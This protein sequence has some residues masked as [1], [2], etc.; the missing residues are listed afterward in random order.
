MR[1]CLVCYLLSRNHCFEYNSSHNEYKKM[2]WLIIKLK[3]SKEHYKNNK[4]ELITKANRNTRVKRKQNNFTIFFIIFPFIQFF[5]S[6]VHFIH[7]YVF[8]L[9][10][11]LCPVL[12]FCI[13]DTFPLVHWIVFCIS[14]FCCSIADIIF[15]YLNSNIFHYIF[16]YFAQCQCIR[17]FFFVFFVCCSNLNREQQ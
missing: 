8:F 5:I 11:L 16:L 9:Y 14:C 4:I 7:L 17:W 10:S 12:F 13:Y 1:F 15:S 3:N 6:F 2:N